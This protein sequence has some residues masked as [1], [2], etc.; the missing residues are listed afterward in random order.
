M[1]CRCCIANEL[2]RKLSTL[3]LWPFLLSGN[4]H[5]VML[6]D[7]DDTTHR[8]DFATFLDDLDNGAAVFAVR[9]A[10]RQDGG[11]PAVHGADM[12]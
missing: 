5:I 9:R 1:T 2:A 10:C 7:S 8:E 4:V 11:S 12:L 3:L 6:D